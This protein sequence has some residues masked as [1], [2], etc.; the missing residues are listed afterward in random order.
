MLRAAFLSAALAAVGAQAGL[1]NPVPLEPT[2]A[3]DSLNKALQGI[4]V[5]VPQESVSVLGLNLTLEE[6]VCG[7]FSLR[8]LSIPAAPL[9]GGGAEFEVALSRLHL[10]CAAKIAKD[11]GKADT[12]HLELALNATIEAGLVPMPNHTVPSS[13]RVEKCNAALP[14]FDASCTPKIAPLCVFIDT[15]LPSI[16]KTVLNT[17]VCKLVE[18]ELAPDSKPAMYLDLAAALLES[19]EVTPNPQFTAQQTEG[20]LAPYS[21]EIATFSKKNK[22]VRIAKLIDFV[23]AKLIDWFLPLFLKK[24]ELTIKLNKAVPITGGVQLVLDTVEL[25]GLNTFTALK[26]LELVSGYTWRS[27]IGLKNVGIALSATL[28]MNET[29]KGMPLQV[30]VGLTDLNLDM[31]TIIAFNESRICELGGTAVKGSIPCALWT[32]VNTKST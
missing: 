32:L 11:G 7:N 18:K 9:A 16:L 24:G 10:S 31:S 1:P 26:P 30:R 3:F 4:T 20:Y 12:V 19:W 15:L 2:S 27:V 29:A 25:S 14:V 28:K 17:T 23:P 22:L 13:L 5:R 8:D 21:S 6:T